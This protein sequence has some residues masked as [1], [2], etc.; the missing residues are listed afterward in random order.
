MNTPVFIGLDTMFSPRCSN[1]TP[2]NLTPRKR[3]CDPVKLIKAG[4]EAENDGWFFGVKKQLIWWVSM[5]WKMFQWVFFNVHHAV[6]DFL[7]QP[8]QQ[9]LSLDEIE[10]RP[11]MASAGLFA[12]EKRELDLWRS[13]MTSDLNCE[14]F[15]LKS[16]GGFLKV[17]GYPKSSKIRPC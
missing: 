8:R 16:D 4:W 11:V 10:W 14:M 2:P 1:G 17:R 5:T 12:H 3:T 9:G 15:S 7:V 13:A 6:W